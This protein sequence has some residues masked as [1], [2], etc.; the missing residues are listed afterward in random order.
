MNPFTSPIAPSLWGRLSSTLERAYWRLLVVALPCAVLG[1]SVLALLTWA[2]N[3]AFEEPVPLPLRVLQDK[4]DTLDPATAW[5]ALAQ[6]QPVLLRD[7]RL[8]EAP[9]WFAFA[10]PAAELDPSAVIELPSRHMTDVTCWDGAALAPLGSADRLQQQG[11]LFASRAGFGLRV[12]GL[13]AGTT[14]LCKASFVGP[15]RLTAQ[16][17]SED[18]LAMASHSFERNAGL[19]EGGILMLALFVLITAL[20]NRNATYVLFAVWLLINLRMGA[21]SAGWDWQWLGHGVPPAWLTP[22]RAITV[23]LLYGVTIVLFCAL[24]REE[25]PRVGF[26]RL[27]TL[28]QWSCAPVLLLSIVLPFAQFLPVVWL[29]TALGSAVLVFLL[30]RIVIITRSTVAAWY[31]ASIGVALLSSAYEVVAAAFGLQTWIG[32]VNSVTAALASSLLAT[33]AIAAQMRQEH[34][35]RVQA[36]AK[37]EHSFEVMPLG[38]FTL[39][40]QGRFVAA[41]PALRAA[42]GINVLA[43]GEHRWG[44]Y[45]AAV[46][47]QHML[48]SLHAQPAAEFELVGPRSRHFL[49]RASLAGE[50]IEGSL[51]DV[52]ERSLA[53]ERLQYLA[54]HDP[55]TRVLN[56]E[57]IRAELDGA[58]HGAGATHAL[59][60]AFLDLDRFKL[61]NDLFGH[62]AGDEVLRQVCARTQALLHNGM[63]LGRM[64]GDEFLLLMPGRSMAQASAL[65]QSIVDSISGQ[66]YRVGGSSFYARGSIGLVEVAAGSSTKD[67]IAAADRACREAKQSRGSHLV[68]FDRHSHALQE[69]EAEIRLAGQLSASDDLPGL[70]LL[71][72]PIMSLREPDQSLDFE[73]LLRMRDADG[74]EVPTARL[75]TAAENSGRMGVIDRWV[76]RRTLAWVREH[77]GRLPRTRFICMNL[78]G[79][80]LNDESFVRDAVELLQRYADVARYLCLEITESVALHD[81]E[82]TRRFIAQVHDLG[83]KVALDDFGAGYTSFSYL[84]GLRGDLLKIDGSFI[85]NMNQHPANLAIVEAI[86]GL[87]R[88]LGMRTVAEWAEDGAT[89]QALAEIGVDYVQGFAVARP[90][91]PERLLDM[92][93]SADLIEDTG[94]LH[95]LL[96]QAWPTPSLFDDSRPGSGPH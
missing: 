96:L 17:W 64:G 20:I 1:L 87:A 68:V 74:E 94:L 42:L 10:V 35:Q 14:V 60:L 67:A 36:Q 54:H 38:L 57:A 32:S 86:V 25:L 52:T 29:C 30:V 2:P 58:L 11:R 12:Q 23:A 70:Y 73:V 95:S 7:T 56:R 33:M 83:A 76:L 82:N 27:V 88:N 21:L 71:M 69:H 85:V 13:A 50:R 90:Q 84:K 91:A 48:Q 62:H 53:T 59:A 5:A 55:L 75:I 93:S 45:F 22:M 81:L 41:N 34:E 78:S 66:P 8:A 43:H 65:C 49:V 15:A 47:W 9:F 72:Q 51:Q 26:R 89:V 3:Y 40:L 4:G 79:A 16:R 19:L 61:I 44:H 80:S 63:H 92:R 77:Q 24:F 39:D 6:E 37:L 46:D 28:M 18:A 31:G